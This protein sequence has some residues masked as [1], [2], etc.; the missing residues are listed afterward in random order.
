MPRICRGLLN[1]QLA[2]MPENHPRAIPGSKSIEGFDFPTLKPADRQSESLPSQT[3]SNF[4]FC[5][6]HSVQPPIGAY[7]NQNCVFSICR[8]FWTKCA[9]KFWTKCR[10][11]RFGIWGTGSPL[12]SS[13][14]FGAGVNVHCG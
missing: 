8:V 9:T 3:I 14:P 12:S 4:S 5:I 13:D 1:H 11:W 10:N 7:R 6:L 2:V